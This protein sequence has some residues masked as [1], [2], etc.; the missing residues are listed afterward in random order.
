MTLYYDSL[1]KRKDVKVGRYL[2]ALVPVRVVPKIDEDAYSGTVQM[3]R[4]KTG[5]RK[6]YVDKACKRVQ[7]IFKNRKGTTPYKIL[8]SDIDPNCAAVRIT[9]ALGI[10]QVANKGYKGY[11]SVNDYDTLETVSIPAALNGVE[12]VTGN[13]QIKPQLFIITSVEQA[14]DGVYVEAKHVFYELLQN[15]TTYKTDN[16]VQGAAACRH[17]L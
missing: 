13:V 10:S 5:T 11:I 6:V 16:T 12:S 17:V 4:I 2:G 14:L 3:V 7:Y 1:G 9:N 8:E 15:A